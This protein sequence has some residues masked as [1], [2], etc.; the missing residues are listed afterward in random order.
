[1]SG[2]SKAG[3]AGTGKVRRA[4]VR[5]G[6]AR[7]STAGQERMGEDGQGVARREEA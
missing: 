4:M 3:M 5:F 7:N 1:M 6:E 2:H